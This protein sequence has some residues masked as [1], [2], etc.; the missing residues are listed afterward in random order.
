MKRKEK[1]TGVNLLNNS[2][3]GVVL[4]KLGIGSTERSTRK[5]ELR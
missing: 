5:F 2:V 4:M 3:S 1:G